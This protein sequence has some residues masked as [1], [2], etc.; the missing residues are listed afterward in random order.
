MKTLLILRHAKAENGTVGSSDFD[1]DLNERG[2]SEAKAVGELIN[3]QELQ[4]DLVL[5]SPALRA[6]RTSE[7]ALKAAGL[8]NQILFEKR[9]YE[10]SSQELLSI[11]S[12]IEEATTSLMLV[13][14]NPGLEDLILILTSQ[15]AHLSPATLVKIELDIARW[16]EVLKNVGTLAW[17]EKPR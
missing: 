6:R 5:S 9:I 14:H 2:R 1:R 13:G 17:L 15:S 10:A 11:L 4:V 16:S 3:K 12:E 7:V 8:S